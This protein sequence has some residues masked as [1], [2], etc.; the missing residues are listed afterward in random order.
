[1]SKVVAIPECTLVQ[2][3]ERE[4]GNIFVQTEIPSRTEKGQVMNLL[5]VEGIFGI[6]DCGVLLGYENIKS[7]CSQYFEF[8]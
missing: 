2:K 7:S 5:G 8:E 3:G 1:M 4:R 6:L